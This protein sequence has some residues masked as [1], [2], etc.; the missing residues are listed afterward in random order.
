MLEPGDQP[1]PL[2]EYQIDEE[3]LFYD[4]TGMMK[5]LGLM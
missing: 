2:E 1:P 3:N 5:Q 4:Q